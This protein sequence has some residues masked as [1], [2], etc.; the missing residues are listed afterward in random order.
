MNS[1]RMNIAPGVTR[2]NSKWGYSLEGTKENLLR[3][4]LAL[5]EWFLDGKVVIR[6]NGRVKRYVEITHE[7]RKGTC[8]QPARGLCRV[9]FSWTAEESERREQEGKLRASMTPR[10]LAKPHL[11]AGLQ[12]LIRAFNMTDDLDHGYGFSAAVRSRALTLVRE[13][14]ALFMESKIESRSTSLGESDPSFQRFM[15]HAISHADEPR[16]DVTETL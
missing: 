16:P 12:L 2:T 13:L 5:P 6:K 14:Y 3:A 7:G 15:A 10:E 8:L 1:E 11:D 9:S 4:G